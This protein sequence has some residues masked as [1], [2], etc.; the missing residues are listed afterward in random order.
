LTGGGAFTRGGVSANGPWPFI[1]LVVNGEGIAIGWSWAVREK[2]RHFAWNELV[3][4][5]VSPHKLSWFD[6]Q[7]VL[8]LFDVNSED[9]MEELRGIPDEAGVTYTTAK[10]TWTRPFTLN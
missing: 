9:T 3:D 10:R 6:D 7:C 8:H 4:V 5:N 1:A 2:M